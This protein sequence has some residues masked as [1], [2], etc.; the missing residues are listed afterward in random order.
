MAYFANGSE[1]M[2]FDVECIECKYYL[3]PCPIAWVQHEYNY[4]A[5]NNKV[6]KAILDALVADNGT[7]FMKQMMLGNKDVAGQ[8][9]LF[10][11]SCD[12]NS[13]NPA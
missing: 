10:P 2:C 11:I 12:N 5:C 1:G 3:E 4:K 7:C 8:M 6:A 13:P 9:P